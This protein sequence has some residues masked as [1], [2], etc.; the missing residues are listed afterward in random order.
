MKN[1]LVKSGEKIPSSIRIIRTDKK[2]PGDCRVETICKH[3]GT[4]T[5]LTAYA[6]LCNTLLFGRNDNNNPQYTNGHKFIFKYFEICNKENKL[7]LEPQIRGRIL[8]ELNDEKM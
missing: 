5:A 6:V 7:L 2:F 4:G 3:C 1:D 8:R